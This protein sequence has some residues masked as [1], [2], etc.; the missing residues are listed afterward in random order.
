MAFCDPPSEQFNKTLSSKSVSPLFP[1]GENWF[2]SKKK[3]FCSFQHPRAPLHRSQK[4]PNT[5]AHRQRRRGKTLGTDSHRDLGRLG[6][7][8]I[9]SP[10]LITLE[11]W[12][13]TEAGAPSASDRVAGGDLRVEQRRVGAGISDNPHFSRLTEH[14]D[15]PFAEVAS[16]PTYKSSTRLQ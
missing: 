2:A 9:T 3:P 6:T 8:S 15:L 1:P 13:G 7:R 16:S 12:H 4:L 5:N 14:G 11:E 10:L